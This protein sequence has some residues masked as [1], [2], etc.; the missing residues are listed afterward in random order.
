MKKQKTAGDECFQAEKAPTPL[1]IGLA[2]SPASHIYSAARVAGPRVDPR[3]GTC[4]GL[5]RIGSVNQ[6]LCIEQ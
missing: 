4:C 5:V 1:R 2:L 6:D 3:R